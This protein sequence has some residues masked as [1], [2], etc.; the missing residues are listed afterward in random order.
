MAKRVE[1]TRRFSVGR[2]VL[3]KAVPY[4]LRRVGA[5]QVHRESTGVTTARMRVNWCSWG[6]A[7]EVQIGDGGDVRAV[8][9]CT[10][11]TQIIDWGKNR[12]N[13]ERLFGWMDDFIELHGNGAGDC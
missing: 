7:M 5:V 10:F 8:S 1:R 4:A 12:R 11:P 13:L 9:R 2:E 3:E 6:E